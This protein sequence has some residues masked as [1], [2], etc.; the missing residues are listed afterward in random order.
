[1]D[2]VCSQD[3]LTRHEETDISDKYEMWFVSGIERKLCVSKR[4]S[5]Y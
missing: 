5:S 2:L 1:M 3:R 4:F